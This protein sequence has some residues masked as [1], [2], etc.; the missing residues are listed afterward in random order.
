MRRSF[1]K[2]FS[3][4]RTP[5]EYFAGDSTLALCCP[6]REDG[7]DTVSGNHINLTNVKFS[8]GAAY[9]NGVNAF[10]V[11]SRTLDLSGTNKLTVLANVKMNVY[12]LTAVQVFVEMSVNAAGSAG[13]FA[14]YQDGT[15][16]GDVLGSYCFG[17]V[18]LNYGAY[19]LVAGRE[20]GSDL[21]L[22]SY[23]S[24]YDMSL[25]SNEVNIFEGGKLLTLTDRIN[26]NNTG[27][28]GNKSIYIG[29]R[30]GTTFFANCSISDLAILKRIVSPEEEADRV[31]W[32]NDKRRSNFI[33]LFMDR[34]RRKSWIDI[35]LKKL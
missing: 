28:F 9:F 20:N 31:A 25:T 11:T 4:T 1:K 26:N 6:L 12:S 13:N 24:T 16:V 10:G 3:S 23:C 18:G 5:A 17:N 2:S 15:A 7:M 30:A 34:K 33:S 14:F 35:Q 8:E 22:H 29:S 32:M 21:N 27:A 19:R